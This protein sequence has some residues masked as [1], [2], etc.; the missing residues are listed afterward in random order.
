[1]IIQLI[2][3]T[4]P[5]RN[6]SANKNRVCY[7]KNK[8]SYPF[9]QTFIA[10]GV[11]ILVL[12]PLRIYQYFNIL[13]S[14]TGF[15][16]KTDFSVYIMYAVIAFIILFSV[17]T[18][19][20]NKKK[21]QQKKISLSPAS[22][23]AVFALSSIGLVFDAIDCFKEYFSLK[24]DFSGYAAQNTNDKGTVIVL[25]EAVF[26]L[27]SAIYFFALASGYLSKKDVAPKLKTIALALP[28]W[29]VMRLL[30][31]FKTKISFIN[32]SDL[33]ITLL[34]IV[35]TMLYLFYFAQTVSEVDKGETYFKM[36]AYG[37][38]AAVFSLTCFIPRLVLLAIGRDDLLCAEYSIELCDLFIPIMIIST[39]I[40]RSY[41]SKK[42]KKS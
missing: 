12:L 39:L 22:G 18:A 16:S 11:S 9:M 41:D 38:P 2:P 26:A 7:M 6:V 14:D 23:A 19:F 13:E 21:L 40:S 42:A 36:Y 34:A 33:F 17:I 31:K 5:R 29:S 37:I 15:Y 28:L 30:L 35:F 8:K 24:T 1:M 32:V 3:N 4:F 25:I 27:I 10:A 20:Y